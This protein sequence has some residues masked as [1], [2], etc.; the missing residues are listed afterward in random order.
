MEGLED[1]QAYAEGDRARARTH[2]VVVPS[3]DVRAARRKLGLSQ[4]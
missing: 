1:A 2:E 3:A 4:A